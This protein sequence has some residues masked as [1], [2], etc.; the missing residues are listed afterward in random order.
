M[1]LKHICSYLRTSDFVT[2]IFVTSLSFVNVIFSSKILFWWIL[3][4]VNTA[5]TVGLFVVAYYDGK[6]YSRLLRFIHDWY[7]IPIIFFGFKEVYFMGY[8][9]HGKDYDELL[10]YLDYALFGANP[11]EWFMQFANPLLTEVL[12]VAYFSYYFILVSVGYE[13]FRDKSFPEFQYAAFLFAYAFYLSYIGYF[14]LP[15]VGPRFILHDFQAL[16][17]D[18]P[19]LFFTEIIRTVINAGESMPVG[20]TNAFELAQRDVFPSG[21]TMLTFI[22][23]YLSFQYRLKVRWVNFTLGVL[24]VISTVYLRYHYVVDIV[25]GIMWWVACVWS[26]PKIHLWWVAKQRELSLRE[27]PVP[28]A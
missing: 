28:T 18:L 19:G 4:L 2:I 7:I 3:V 12:Q 25:A 17:S 8:P 1:Y 5:F 6:R 15:A 20:A 16:D 9:I 13:L 27:A 10:I 14:L 23:M 26:A 24:L 11:T 21:H 22:A